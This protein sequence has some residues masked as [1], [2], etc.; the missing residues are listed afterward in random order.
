MLQAVGGKKIHNTWGLVKGTRY[1]TD[2][3]IRIA[4]DS[5]NRHRI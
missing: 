5:P 2:T 1:K 4:C 3:N